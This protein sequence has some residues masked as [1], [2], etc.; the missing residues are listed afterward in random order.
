M[1]ENYEE[2]V[3]RGRECLSALLEE[4]S[5]ILDDPSAIEKLPCQEIVDTLMAESEADLRRRTGFIIYMYLLGATDTDPRVWLQEMIRAETGLVC[6][7][8]A[9]PLGK[10]GGIK[11]AKE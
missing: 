8:E 5:T 1:L 7:I 3:E 6:R 11:A 4:C 10:I 2:A 9:I